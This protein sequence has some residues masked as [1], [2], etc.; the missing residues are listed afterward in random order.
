MEKEL[1]LLEVKLDK[2]PGDI[3]VSLYK[4]KDNELSN[5][6]KFEHKNVAIVI[7]CGYT[8][9]KVGAK[10]KWATIYKVIAPESLIRQ[11]DKCG[12]D[13]ERRKILSELI[14]LIKTLRDYYQNERYNFGFGCVENMLEKSLVYYCSLKERSSGW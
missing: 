12:R 1:N 6:L 2:I 5:V 3:Y 13:S 8:T 14:Y 10:H 11:F 7:G 9:S 4:P